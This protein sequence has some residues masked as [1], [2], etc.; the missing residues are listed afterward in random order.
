MVDFSNFFKGS[1]WDVR[2]RVEGEGLEKLGGVQKF[3]DKSL[4]ILRLVKLMDVYFWST[5]HFETP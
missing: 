3:S 2:Y 1:Y 5:G 4:R